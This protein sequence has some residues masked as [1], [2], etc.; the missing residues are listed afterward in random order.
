MRPPARSE[1]QRGTSSRRQSA[2]PSFACARP[3]PPLLHLIACARR[4]VAA[5]AAQALPDRGVARLVGEA[6]R[7]PAAEP[8][9][10]GAAP[11]ARPRKGEGVLSPCAPRSAITASAWKRLTLRRRPS[12]Q[13]CPCTSPRRCSTTRWGRRA[14]TRRGSRCRPCRRRAPRSSAAGRT[15]STLSRTC[16]RACPRTVTWRLRGASVGEIIKS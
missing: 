7:R 3:F 8:G 13:A 12:S 4:V 6:A 15:A 10:L 9:A 1:G 16:A 11:K 2:R 5:G 14:W